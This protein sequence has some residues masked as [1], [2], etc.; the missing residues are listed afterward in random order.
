MNEEPDVDQATSSASTSAAS[1]ELT[2]R[3]ARDHDDDQKQ[4]ETH[5]EEKER[6]AAGGL[7]L[8]ACRADHFIL[9]PWEIDRSELK[10]GPCVGSGASAEVFRASWHG[11]DVAVKRLRFQ[12]GFGGPIQMQQHAQPA[13]AVQHS[14]RRELS[15]LLGLR[16]P[17]LVLFMGAATCSAP[18]LIVSEL[19]EGGTLFQLLH[20]RPQLRVTWPQRLKLAVDTAKGMNFLHR[21]RIV[22]RDL[23]SLN[24]LLVSW[25]A[26]PEDVPWVKISDFGLSRQLP[27]HL[28]AQQR[29]Q[30]SDVMTGGL[31]TCLWMAPEILSGS[32]NYTE[33]V[34]VYSFGVVLWELICQRVPFDGSGLVEPIAVAIAVSAGRRPDLHQVPGDC[35]GS[36]RMT[37]EQ[38]WAHRA[39]ERPSFD[40]IL[41]DLKGLQ[42]LP[43]GSSNLGACSQRSSSARLARGR[44]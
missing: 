31:G 15:V 20:S 36:F 6:V 11:T 24:L 40:I 42:H 14:W 2:P 41:E 43:S 33:K 21:R 30:V 27:T 28:E 4:S 25:I 34:D 37:M 17:N 13:Q 3:R 22:H 38:C 7:G 44:F 16:H 5:A 23:K 26:A 32:V 12:G 1:G 39:I 29:S 19:C 8:D 9:E 35:P 18:T 10:L